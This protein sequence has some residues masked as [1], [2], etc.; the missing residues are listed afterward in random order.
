MDRQKRGVN[1]ASACRFQ[2]IRA[3]L[4]SKRWAEPRPVVPEIEALAVGHVC[5]RSGNGGRMIQSGRQTLAA[6]RATRRNHLAA[7]HRRHAGAETMA[8]LSHDVAGLKG[9][10]HVL[11]SG[12]SDRAEHGPTSNQG[13]PSSETNPGL[14]RQNLPAKPSWH[15]GAWSRAYAGTTPA[16]QM[17]QLDLNLR[18]SHFKVMIMA[19]ECRT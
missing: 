6:A 17:N 16:S 10:F 14:A 1:F 7:T 5:N 8:P 11:C 19:F 3:F 12:S 13:W 15:R 18:P 9:A 2:K 4:Q